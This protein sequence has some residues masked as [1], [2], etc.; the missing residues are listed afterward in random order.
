MVVEQ[1]N[2][3]TTMHRS[4]HAAHCPEWHATVLHAA[5]LLT[6]VLYAI[7]SERLQ[8]LC[9]LRTKSTPVPA[10]DALSS[11]FSAQKSKRRRNR[12]R[13]KQESGETVDRATFLNISL[14]RV[15]L[16]CLTF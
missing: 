3:H 6:T 7:S 9:V 16:L 5:V 15:L 10:C 2:L 14:P 11:I 12:A 4:T 1:T 8:P 13:R